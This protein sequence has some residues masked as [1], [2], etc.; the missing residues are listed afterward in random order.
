MALRQVNYVDVV[1]DPRSIYSGVVVA[2]HS[3]L[4]AAAHGDLRAEIAYPRGAA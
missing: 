1:A 2:I 3:E 4:R